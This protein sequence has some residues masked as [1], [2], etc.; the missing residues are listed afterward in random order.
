MS[1]FSQDWNQFKFSHTCLKEGQSGAQ[2]TFPPIHPSDEHN[3]QHTTHHARNNNMQQ[4]NSIHFVYSISFTIHH[5]SSI[6]HHPSSINNLLQV[7]NN[8]D[9]DTMRDSSRNQSDNTESSSLSS[10]RTTTTSSNTN[11]T[12]S[13]SILDNYGTRYEQILLHQRELESY[14]ADIISKSATAS[15]SAS[16]ASSSTLALSSSSSSNRNVFSNLATAM[17]MNQ[18]AMTGM[19]QSAL[20][21]AKKEIKQTKQTQSAKTTTPKTSKTTTRTNEKTQHKESSLEKTISGLSSLLE[22]TFEEQHFGKHT[23]YHSSNTSD[24]NIDDDLVTKAW[25]LATI[26]EINGKSNSRSDDRKNRSSEQRRHHH[27]QQQQQGQQQ[28]QSPNDIMNYNEDEL[29]SQIDAFFESYPEC[30]G[31]NTIHVIH[32]YEMKSSSS[33]S[34]SSSPSSSSSKLVTHENEISNKRNKHGGNGRIRTTVTN[35]IQIHSHQT[36]NGSTSKNPMIKVRRIISYLKFDFPTHPIF[37]STNCFCFF[38]MHLLSR[39]HM[40]IHQQSQQPQHPMIRTNINFNQIILIH[41]LYQYHHQ[42]YHH[43]MYIMLNMPIE[44]LTIIP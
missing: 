25:T 20:M 4:S 17:T 32:R 27:Q 11:T 18:I 26:D 23:N 43:G 2:Q 28:Q 12:R 35:E 36:Q 24:Y 41:H 19:L 10:S 1:T 9:R 15:K 13:S 34:S 16:P 40:Q 29:N 39:I 42:H 7:Q 44:V 22:D 8:F 30:K 21:T 33:S 37:Y 6:I 31:N 3:I 5:P 38:F 14:C